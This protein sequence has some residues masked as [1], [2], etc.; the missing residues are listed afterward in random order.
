MSQS[1]YME[2]SE[3]L[4][5]LCAAQWTSGAAGKYY[6]GP[7]IGTTD[8]AFMVCAWRV[9]TCYDLFP[10]PQRNNAKSGV[11]GRI[12][13]SLTMWRGGCYFPHLPKT[14]RFNLRVRRVDTDTSRLEARQPT[15]GT[16]MRVALQFES[17]KR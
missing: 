3:A 12:G 6:E 10:W 8:W 16:P 13:I 11:A 4:R 15:P 1:C 17:V 9:R 2:E 5:D 7:D 14:D